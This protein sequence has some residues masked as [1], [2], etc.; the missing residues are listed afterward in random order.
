MAQTWVS[1]LEDPNYGKLTI[2]TLLKVASAFDV[3]LQIDFVPYSKILWDAVC[4]TGAAFS[5][6]KFGDDI[7]FTANNAAYLGPVN[8]STGAL[9]ATRVIAF[10]NNAGTMSATVNAPRSAPFAGQQ[11]IAV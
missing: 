11:D 6:P 10:P 7:G 3:G 4:L 1:K 2:S 9:T 5:V 8:H